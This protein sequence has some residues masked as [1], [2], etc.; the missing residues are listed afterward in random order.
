MILTE[1]ISTNIGCYDDKNAYTPYLDAFARENIR[2][3]YCSSAAP[4]C[5]AARTSLSLG[6]FASSAGVGQHRS[7]RRLPESIKVFAHYLKEA[8]YV[9]AIGKT[10]FNMP[11]NPGEGYD[12]VLP[13]D[14]SDSTILADTI[15]SVYDQCEDKPFFILQTTHVTHQSQYGFTPDATAHRKT[16]PRLL[17][18][19]HLNR[20]S[21]EVPGYHFNTAE[22]RE[23]WAQYQEKI[24]TMD[25]MF[26]EVIAQLKKD[27]LY[28]DTVIFFAGDNGHGIPQGKCVLWDEGVHVPL[29][30]HIPKRYASQ[31]ETT[32]DAWG[33]TIC[34]R[35]VSFVDFGATALSLAGVDIPENF[36][37]RAFLGN[38][39]KDAEDHIYSFSERVD[40]C[41]ENSRCIRDMHYLY[42]CDF[43]FTKYKRLNAYQTVMAPW[44]VHAQIVAAKKER[45]PD[46]DRRS[47]FR[48][49][50]RVSEQLYDME[51]DKPQLHNLAQN[52]EMVD[53][54][55]LMRKRL[56]EKLVAYHDDAFM[57]E[58]MYQA[59]ADEYG[60]TAHDVLRDDQLYPISKIIALWNSVIEGEFQPAY[61]ALGDKNAVM[62]LWACRFLLDHG[63]RENIL[64]LADD[65]NETVK[66][67]ALYRLAETEEYRERSVSSLAELVMHTDNFCLLM[68]I[69]DLIAGWKKGIIPPVFEA[70]CR[71]H[72][73]KEYISGPS[74]YKQG[75]DLGLH[76]LAL[77]TGEKIPECEWVEDWT[78]PSLEETLRIIDELD[79]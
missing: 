77:R 69:T 15:K 62:R 55:R 38:A 16:M 6:M 9:T 78:I 12:I 34:D 27:G 28:D 51:N 76:M 52:P 54:I 50:P 65:E 18:E 19:E 35:F 46:T 49:L 41:F 10:D 4:V 45:V 60:M 63:C 58:P 13:N 3:T 43:S 24:T 14:A 39:Y 2:F 57:P 72:W 56:Q 64:R 70:L 79:L 8:G 29:L 7:E 74:R 1:D 30:A 11:W 31:L 22:A 71:R 44:F 73:N 61:D 47:Y 21:I 53:R 5:S 25:R 32:P 33:N 48:Q 26:G 37:G 59:F 40:E 68:F 17:Q 36:Q 75:L 66:S 20:D 23:I 67:Y 42:L